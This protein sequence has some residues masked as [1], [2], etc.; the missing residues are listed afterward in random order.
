[1]LPN[2]SQSTQFRVRVRVLS[3]GV[4]SDYGDACFITS[5]AVARTVETLDS[6]VFD[7]T[8]SPNP[9]DTNFGMFLNATST[10][11]VSIR[12]YDMIG[13]LM[14]QRLVKATE[15]VTQEVGNN[16]P[17]GV[18]NV[19]VSQGAEVKTLRMIKR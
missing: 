9:F 13:K 7:V 18:Y 8:A 5:P 11:D 14:E 12:V 15:V 10:E 2:Y 6:N 1:M 3:S 4:F 19:I 17:S 16:Y